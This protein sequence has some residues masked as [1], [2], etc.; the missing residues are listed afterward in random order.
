MRWM[1][2]AA[3]LAVVLLLQAGCKNEPEPPS[4]PSTTTTTSTAEEKNRYDVTICIMQT[5]AGVGEPDTKER[6]VKADKKTRVHWKSHG[7]AHL[8]YFEDWP[9][10]DDPDD[11]PTI[12][13]TTYNVIKVPAAGAGESR[14]FVLTDELGAG[15]QK[16]HSY[17]LDTDPPSSTTPPNGPAII[18]EG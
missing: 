17:R 10:D 2:I 6:V 5:G 9:F 3:T 15:E 11:K 16:K 18:G 12:G 1:R 14:T 13:S 8:V 7:V 4:E